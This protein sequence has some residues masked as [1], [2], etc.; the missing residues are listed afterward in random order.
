[1][2]ET[3]RAHIPALGLY[4]VKSE[5][6]EKLQLCLVRSLDT[7]E[8][9]AAGLQYFCLE[10]LQGFEISLRGPPDCI[11]LQYRVNGAIALEQLTFLVSYSY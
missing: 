6:L 7:K 11:I 8:V 10:A 5:E 1:M 4:G 3:E 9:R 2:G